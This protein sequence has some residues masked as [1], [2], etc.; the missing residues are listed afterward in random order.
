MA[1]Q[2]LANCESNYAKLVQEC[3]IEEVYPLMATSFFIVSVKIA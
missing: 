1:K 3:R 2:P